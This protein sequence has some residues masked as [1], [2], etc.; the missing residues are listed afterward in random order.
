MNAPEPS[1]DQLLAMAYV[2]DELDPETRVA[3]EERLGQEAA[4]RREVSQLRELELLARAAVPKEP[5]DHEWEALARDPVQ[6]GA[7]GLGWILAGLGFL[8]LSLCALGALFLAEGPP[9]LKLC[10]AAL[11]LGGGLLFGA[12]LR[13]RLRTLPLDP[14]RKVQR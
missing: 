2:D 11:L 8:G 10:L 3:F 14:Y 13:A 1:R 9:A 12:T 7:L 5:M 4:L 6:R